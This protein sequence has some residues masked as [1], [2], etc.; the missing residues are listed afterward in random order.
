[1]VSRRPSAEPRQ[2]GED[3]HHQAERVASAA[4]HSWRMERQAPAPGRRGASE[5]VVAT[6]AGFDHRPHPS[7]VLPAALRQHREVQGEELRRLAEDGLRDHQG[8]DDKYPGLSP[9][10][11]RSRTQPRGGSR[12]A[13][14]QERSGRSEKVFATFDYLEVDENASVWYKR[15]ASSIAAAPG[16][17]GRRRTQPCWRTSRTSIGTRFWRP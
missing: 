13:R 5:R 4:H 9:L 16:C 2:R 12:P 6:P 14:D 3:G 17:G 10:L 7:A 1:M 11:V 8:H 15:E